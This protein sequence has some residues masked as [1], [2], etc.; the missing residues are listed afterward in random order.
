M[1]DRRVTRLL[2]VMAI[3]E[4]IMGQGAALFRDGFAQS[5]PRMEQLLPT[6]LTS[7]SVILMLLVRYPL[8]R[9]L[10]RALIIL[11][12][13]SVAFMAYY[14]ATSGAWVEAIPAATAA[15]LV[16]LAPWMPRESAWFKEWEARDLFMGMMAASEAGIAVLAVLAP[17]LLK[18]HMPNSVE[19]FTPLMFLAGVGGALSF[20]LPSPGAQRRSPVRQFRL[21]G[22][23]ALPMVMAAESFR[24]GHWDYGLLWAAAVLA[25]LFYR[26]SSH[27]VL[28]S[29]AAPAVPAGS[30]MEDSLTRVERMV[31]SWT[32]L[33]ALA[34]ALQG[35]LRGKG[36][37]F[38]EMAAQYF[39]FALSAFN[40]IFHL[41]F[42][43]FG[44]PRQRVLIQVLFVTA[45]VGLLELASHDIS[46]G[47]DL[48]VLLLVGPLVTTRALGLVAGVVVLACSVV[49]ANL[50]ELRQWL[51]DGVKP[52]VW[53]GESLIKSTVIVIASG[54]G[55]RSASD[56][57]R[58]VRQLAQQTRALRESEE[59]FRSAFLHSAVGKALVSLDGRYLQVNGS[60][61]HMLGY[62]EDELLGQHF[63]SIT[64]P[65]DVAMQVEA[66]HRLITGEVQSVQ[67]EKRY[68][69]R[70]GHIVWAEVSLALLHDPAGRPLH[71]V[72][73]VQDVTGRKQFE[74]KLTHLANYDSLT[75][76]FNRRRFQAELERELAAA[77]AQGTTGAVIFLDLDQFKDV[78]D[79]L[80]HRAGDD[81]LVSIGQ[82]IGR[83][84]EATD[85]LS[86]PGG[87]EFSV[88]LPQADERR[89]RAVAGRLVEAV[90]RFALVAGGQL[91]RVTA[92]VGIALFPQHGS[93]AEEAM[94]AAD[95]AMYQ[96][97]D[98]GGNQCVFH[99]LV[100]DWQ[101]E[102][103]SRRIWEFR[104]RQALESNRFVLYCQ[105]ILD[106]QTESVERYEV[107]LRMRGQ[108]GEV[109]PPAD[110]LGVAERY[111]LIKQVDRWVVTNTIRFMGQ[112]LAEGRELCLEAN[113]SGKAWSDPELPL[114]I[115]D[116][117]TKWQVPPA[118][119]T[120]E[121]TETA[122]ITNVYEA[123]KLVETLR[124][125]GC[126]M[127]L[128]DFGAGYSSFWHLKNLPVDCL[129][130]DG[131]FIRNLPDDEVDQRLVAAMIEVARGLGKET[132]VE[133]VED[134]D[135]L[136]LVCAYG[137]DFA[138]GY[139]VGK[140]QPLT[141][142]AAGVGD[143]AGLRRLGS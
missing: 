103:N 115:R 68:V 131:S 44:S 34:M 101:E 135:T 130:I 74:A 26:P 12:A 59:R 121:I 126:R 140:P 11:P 99:Q 98:A 138:Q 78:N 79:S 65:E 71:V 35:V 40:L 112:Q 20:G 70:Q 19:G 13:V 83:Q 132:I 58:L 50:P 77:K 97:K 57:R 28:N 46:L 51:V 61:C 56:Q 72:S 108:D 15:V 27:A 120:L 80:G 39:V 119:L 95:T 2:V 141:D 43:R 93:T 31:E 90:G 86:R 81:I 134:E 10:T 33:L 89:A 49:V 3:I 116:E 111:G 66:R 21:V 36:L 32:W 52:T 69:H 22:G 87:D 14:F 23:A 91:I 16:G 92:S 82:M 8:E 137:A 6:V 30:E 143:K 73:E 76:L 110:F 94:A 123:K 105:P 124:A 48:V 136:R 63:D 129:K 139:Y 128:D 102:L 107:L 125:L 104:I 117:L 75:N 24:I 64:H 127:A 37:G 88:L 109:I 9:R 18:M 84:L 106:L 100:E 54:A 4:M 1:A 122:A 45:A 67:L 47:R 62:F 7:G 133:F 53:M 142:L 42:P 17:G 41:T 96:A 5:D 25:I 29:E 113:L 118:N 85:I 60:F 55:L 114:L 38:S